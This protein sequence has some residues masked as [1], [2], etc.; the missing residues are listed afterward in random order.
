[1]HG[2]WIY[3]PKNSSRR[4]LEKKQCL[5]ANRR[6]MPR[7]LHQP[8]D[9]ARAVPCRPQAGEMWRHRAP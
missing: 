9:I 4:E 5:P 3:S 1:M 8:H 2:V 6:G 7:P